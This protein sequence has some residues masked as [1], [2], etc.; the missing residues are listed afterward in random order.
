MLA[1]VVGWDLYLTTRSPVVLGNVGLVQIIPV[2]LF[3][4]RRFRSQE[5]IR[6]WIRRGYKARDG[7]RVKVT[8]KRRAGWVI[9][10]DPVEIAK[11]DIATDPKRRFRS[12][13]PAA[14]AA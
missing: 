12:G 10:V 7:Q 9:L 2:L 13:F 4:L 11:A 5:A 3:N 1:T 8:V 14:V 6:A